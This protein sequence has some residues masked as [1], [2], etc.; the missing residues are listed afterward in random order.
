VTKRAS[1][2]G[3][4]IE[5]LTGFEAVE[6]D[7]AFLEAPTGAGIELIQYRTPEGS[8]PNGLSGPNTKGIRHIAF[9][10]TEVDMMVASLKTADVELLSDIQQVSAAQVDYAEERKRIVYCRDP[11]DNL[12]ELCEFK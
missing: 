9:R 8:R 10:V 12:L 7:V 6:A 5:A 2:S 1:I 4:W 3:R 11:E